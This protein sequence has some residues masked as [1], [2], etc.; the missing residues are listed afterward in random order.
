[1]RGF[2]DLLSRERKRMTIV[3]AG[4]V[5]LSLAAMTVSATTQTRIYNPSY[6]YIAG[7]VEN[8]LGLTDTICGVQLPPEA[9]CYGRFEA[10]VRETTP[11]GKAICAA[12]MSAKIQQITVTYRTDITH[13]G[14]CEIIR[15][16]S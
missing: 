16:E 11:G 7:F 10:W 8:P 12:L 4:S 2:C 13:P 6:K 5:A 1:M 3:I 15:V 9:D 14:Q